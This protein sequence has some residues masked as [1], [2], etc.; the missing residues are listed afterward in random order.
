MNKPLLALLGNTSVSGSADVELDE[1]E[2]LTTPVAWFTM[3]QGTIAN[4]STD[5]TASMA[6]IYLSR[7][8]NA[9][10]AVNDYYQYPT[11]RSVSLSGVHHLK[12]IVAYVE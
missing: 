4:G 7:P 9:G 12:L 3:P 11:D 6:Q 2:V 8:E 5:V 10:T 1:D